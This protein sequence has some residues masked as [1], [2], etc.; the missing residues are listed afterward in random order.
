MELVLHPPRTVRRSARRLRVLVVTGMV[1][2]GWLGAVLLLPVLLGWQAAVVTEPQGEYAAG[3]LVVT[4]AVP[5]SDV[6]SDDVVEIAGGIRRVSVVRPGLLEVEG[7]ADVVTGDTP[8]LERVVLTLPGL[9]MPLMG[10]DGVVRWF[11][12]VGAVAILGSAGLARVGAGRV[13][14]AG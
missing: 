2:V 14:L 10:A 13:H 11:V 4:Q 6:V 12:L 1:L 8:I 7:T 9:G 3:T 5:S